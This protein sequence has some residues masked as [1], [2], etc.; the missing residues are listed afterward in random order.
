MRPVGSRLPLDH[1]EATGANFVTDAA[2][3]A[4]RD[5]TA[6]PEPQQSIDHQRLWAD[7]LSSQALALNLFGELAGDPAAAQHAV[8]TLCPDAPGRVREVRFAHSP[9][10]FDPDYLNSLRDFSAAFLLELDGGGRGIVA[11]GTLFHERLKAETPKPAN[12]P[13]YEGVAARSGAFRPGAIEVLLGRTELC[14]VWLE[15]LLALSMLQHPAGEWRWARYVV[16]HPGAN[17]D[18]C[19]LVEEYRGQ[20]ADATTFGSITLESLL[21]SGALPPATTAAVSARYLDA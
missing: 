6:T 17:P 11:I 4:A 18:A 21:A 3:S 14:V 19:T 8:R 9:G 20:L 12:R 7:L 10:R 5:R 15:H 2:W 16:A 13:W 1:A